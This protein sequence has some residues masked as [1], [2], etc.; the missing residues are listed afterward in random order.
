VLTLK[1]THDRARRGLNISHL[2]WYIKRHLLNMRVLPSKVIAKVLELKTCLPHAVS[3][4][5]HRALL[6]RAVTTQAGR[7]T[8]L[9]KSLRVERAKPLKGKPR[10]VQQHQE[11]GSRGNRQQKAVGVDLQVSGCTTSTWEN[12]ACQSPTFYTAVL[13]LVVWWSGGLVVV[14]VVVVAAAAAAAVA[15]V[16]RT[17]RFMHWRDK[18]WMAYQRHRAQLGGSA[19]STT[20]GQ[21][22]IWLHL[23]WLPRSSK[24]STR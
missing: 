11:V 23:S 13:V 20:A 22:I 10:E 3:P 17:T 14:V 24:C 21:K 1:V 9:V 4:A 15:M 2:R 19:P 8:N 18:P 5:L 12:Q 7:T 6:G 16:V